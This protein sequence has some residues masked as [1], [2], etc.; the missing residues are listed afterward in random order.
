[1]YTGGHPR[2]PPYGECEFLQQTHRRYA[3]TGGK[4]L[5]LALFEVVFPLAVIGEVRD[6]VV[7][8]WRT[9][10]FV[11]FAVLL[12]GIGFVTE[13]SHATTRDHH[14]RHRVHH[15]VSLHNHPAST[16][17]VH[18]HGRHQPVGGYSVSIGSGYGQ[19]AAKAQEII[20]SCGSTIISGFRPGARIAGSGHAS[21]HASGRAI[22]IRGNPGCIYSHLHGWPG[23][24]S[25]DYGAVQH[26]HIS[27]GGFEDGVRFSHH[28]GGHSWHHASGHGRHQHYASL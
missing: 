25:V 20:A 22:D 10:V 11:F 17:V 2:A 28:R 24:Y 15:H 18:F 3:A 4:R 1:L 26:V 16:R 6:G 12:A 8:Y 7:M 21:L 27:L 13:P 23:G 9:T 14:H 5:L 19:L